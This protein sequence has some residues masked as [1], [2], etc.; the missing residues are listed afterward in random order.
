MVI[1]SKKS[2]STSSHFH[3]H[4]NCDDDHCQTGDLMV[5]MDLM[6][7]GELEQPRLAWSAG[8]APAPGFFLLIL[9][10]IFYWEIF[11]GHF[12][13]GRPQHQVNHVKKDLGTILDLTINLTHL[14][15]LI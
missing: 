13:I 1:G 12:F 6:V 14:L 5:L 7:P 11:I 2:L 10:D 9:L 4:S 15:Q 3:V 8:P